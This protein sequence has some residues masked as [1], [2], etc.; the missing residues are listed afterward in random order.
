MAHEVGKLQPPVARDFKH[1]IVEPG[2]QLLDAGGLAAARGAEDVER[3]ARVEEPDNEVAAR[4][5]EDV[6][7]VDGRGVTGGRGLA[8][9]D[10]AAFL[11]AKYLPRV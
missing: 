6:A 9:D 2:A 1:G 10:C 8:L 4:L 11:A 7:G 5:M 3:V